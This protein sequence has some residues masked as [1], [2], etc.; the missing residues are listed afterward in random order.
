MKLMSVLLRVQGDNPGQRAGL[1]I[2]CG[3]PAV[4]HAE[5]G[6]IQSVFAA[7]GSPPRPGSDKANRPK[8]LGD[9]LLPGRTGDDG[10]D[11]GRNNFRGLFRL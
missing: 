1:L 5:I 10:I 11:K 3:D 4:H 7:T 6:P 9:F 8:H 2:K